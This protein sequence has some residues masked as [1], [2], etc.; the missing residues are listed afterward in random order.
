MVNNYTHA[1]LRFQQLL[2]EAREASANFRLSVIYNDVILRTAFVFN[3]IRRSSS[4]ESRRYKLDKP[5]EHP[6][7]V[8]RDRAGFERLTTKSAK[9]YL[10]YLSTEF[11]YT[12]VTAFAL[13]ENKNTLSVDEDTFSEDGNPWVGQSMSI[14][15]V[16]EQSV[17]RND[18]QTVSGCASNNNISNFIPPI[19]CLDVKFPDFHTVSRCLSAPRFRVLHTL[20]ENLRRAE[21]Y[22]HRHS[23]KTPKVFERYYDFVACLHFGLLGQR[24]PS[25]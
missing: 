10:S 23:G 15:W 20:D 3:A 14:A 19:N 9:N 1:L 17:Q 18:E 11:K 13:S 6:L 4:P 7:F 8:L 24:M 21:G 16:Q 12:T 5:Q 22:Q 2:I 25:P